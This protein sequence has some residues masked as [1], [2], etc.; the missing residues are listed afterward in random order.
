MIA[1]YKRWRDKA[2]MGVN[3]TEHDQVADSGSTIR[4]ISILKSYYH[5]FEEIMGTSRI[6]RHLI[7]ES[8]H[9][10][11]VKTDVAPHSWRLF[12]HG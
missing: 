10:D 2:G 3:V 5:E 1:L 4:E 8:G 9:P 6:L 7:E 12:I 11:R